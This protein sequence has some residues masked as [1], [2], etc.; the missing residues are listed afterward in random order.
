[1]KSARILVIGAAFVA[2]GLA[3]SQGPA[4]QSPPTQV[5]AKQ[6]PVERRFE[7]LE[8]DLI[9]T[10]ERAEALALEVAE[11]KTALSSTIKFVGEQAK[12]AQAMAETLDASEQ[13]GFTAG[14][15]FES[16]HLLLRGW[17]E[18]LAAAQK[19]LPVVAEPKRAT[20]APAPAQ[21]GKK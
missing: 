2:C 5:P 10:R 15:N 11:L 13:A 17:R 4:T 12:A 8:S 3:F 14:I 7:L 19:N 18:Q 16:R 6:D 9:S 20:S 21:A 1:M